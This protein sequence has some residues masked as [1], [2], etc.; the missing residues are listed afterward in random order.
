M[1]VLRERKSVFYSQK[2]KK[3]QFNKNPSFKNRK[4][5]SY[6]FQLVLIC[7][8]SLEIEYIT[9]KVTLKL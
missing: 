4:K 6:P 9:Q 7:P 8:V 5:D 3:T 2:K 1:G